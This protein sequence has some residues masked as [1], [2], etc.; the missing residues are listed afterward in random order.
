MEKQ[1]NGTKGTRKG[2]RAREYRM[3]EPRAPMETT[4]LLAAEAVESAVQQLAR[5]I[6]EA[7]PDLEAAAFLGILS[8]G[9]PLAQRL[10]ERI[11][12]MTGT[13]PKVGA[14]ATTLYR[15]D[16]R[17]GTGAVKAGVGD[18]YFDFSIDG[19]TVVLVDDVVHRGRTIRAAMDELM[20]YGRPARV[21]LAALVDRA[22]RELPIQPDY[23]GWRLGEVEG[24]RVTVRL[25]EVDGEDAVLVEQF[26]PRPG[27]AETEA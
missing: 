25:A 18:T 23:R 19:I 6:V 8:R 21:Q 2:E 27:A 9:Y 1:G 16:L 12:A 3:S 14:L 5:E 4:V 11:H 7:L 13:R 22:G 17:T 26:E 10:A 20:D 15:D 24:G